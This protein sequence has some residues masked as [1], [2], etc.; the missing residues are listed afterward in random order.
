MKENLNSLHYT[1]LI[2]INTMYNIN[3][4]NKLWERNLVFVHTH[5]H[6]NN[7]YIIYRSFYPK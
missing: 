7:K 2:N 5:T 1:N 6:K 4:V 3:T